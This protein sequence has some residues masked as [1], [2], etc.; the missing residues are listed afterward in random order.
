M[1][2]YTDAE[3]RSFFSG[4]VAK[5]RAGMHSASGILYSVLVLVG[6][7]WASFAI[8]NLNAGET[9]P[10]TLGIYVI[11]ILV[12]VFADALMIYAR[13]GDQNRLE[14][15]IA[16]AVMSIALIL[17][18][19][20]SFFSVKSSHFENSIK[21]LNGW[22]CMSNP[23]LFLLLAISIALSLLLTGFDPELPNGALD[24]PIDAVQD[25]G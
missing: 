9:T 7:A 20:A 25:R 2:I 21:V 6:V 24:T 3:W 18:V 19:I 17:L 1:S 10:E 15:A 22:R 23:V 16:V 12:T 4:C 8:P 13:G 11:G 5:F 14:Q